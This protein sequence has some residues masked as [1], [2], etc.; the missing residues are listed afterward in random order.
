VATPV[1]AAADSSQ[2]AA[3]LHM[4]AAALALPLL[5]LVGLAIRL[6]PW[7]ANRPLHHDEALYGAWAQLIASGQDPLLLTSWVDKPPLTLYVLAASLRLFGVSEV[8]LR[9]PGM[10]ASG[11][12]I[13]VTYGF[14]RQGA[15]PRIAVLAATLVALSPFAIAFGPTAFTDGWLAL[16]LVAA[17]WAALA[18]RP[19]ATG[20]LLGLAV[21]T[22]QQGVLAVPLILPLLALNVPSGRRWR[23]YLT[24]FGLALLGFALIL[25]PVTWWDS[26]RWHNRPSFWDR[27]LQTYGGLIL[28]PIRDWPTRA[29]AWGGQLRYLF[30]L[31]GLGWAALGVLVLGSPARL[32]RPAD[33]AVWLERVLALY[34]AGY[35]AL[36]VV[37]TFQPWDRYLLP[38]VPL[39]CVLMAHR[40]VRLHQRIRGTPVPPGVQIAR[41]NAFYLV[42]LALTTALLW[43]GWL[44]AS[45]DLPAGSN[46]GVYEGVAAA[47]Q[48]VRHQDADAVI[49][50]RRLG[51][52]LDYYLFDAPQERRWYGDAI[53]L[54][55]DAGETGVSEPDRTQ[56]LVLPE[57]DTPSL[58]ELQVALA[59][60]DLR[61]E[62]A[63][64]I[65]DGNDSATITIYRLASDPQAAVRP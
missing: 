51:W 3:A 53:K 14:A 47:A 35:L 49:H 11:L 40:V 9:L 64:R 21:A 30:G 8:A 29:V 65:L 59:R 54:A 20:V 48:F 28:A 37:V 44:A 55:S 60:Q 6:A 2:G 17:G 12:L 38:L 7:L 13:P 63:A 58:P 43:G 42:A 27:S 46:G 52:H 19:L 32:P 39:L 10:I 56:W 4:N 41:R 15:N 16:W 57:W 62:T 26:L 36:H 24:T 1:S 23:A 45:G 33:R 18:G 25:A 5:V 22:K 61:L 50:Y 31:P 34:V